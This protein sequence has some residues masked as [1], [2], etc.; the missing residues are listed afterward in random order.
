MAKTDLIDQP[1][2]LLTSFEGKQSLCLLCPGGY[3]LYLY[4]GVC[5][6]RVKFKPKNIGNFLPKDI[7]YVGE[8][9]VLVINLMAR[10]Y[11]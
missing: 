1:K 4:T 2:K 7:H 9:C 3:V 10:D 8:N 5:V 6:W 11:F